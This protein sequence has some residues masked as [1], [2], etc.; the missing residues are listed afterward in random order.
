[1]IVSVSGSLSKAPLRPEVCRKCHVLHCHSKIKAVIAATIYSLIDV[2]DVTCTH[3][4]L[5]RA[6]LR[7]PKTKDREIKGTSGVFDK[8]HSLPVCLSDVQA[9]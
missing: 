1:M 2:T 4:P 8:H 9:I 5:A 6:N 7:D 3:N